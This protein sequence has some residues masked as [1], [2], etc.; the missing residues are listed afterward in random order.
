MSSLP[1]MPS[2]ADRPHG[3]RVRYMTGC[4]CEPCRASNARYESQRALARLRGEGAH[5]VPAKAARLHIRRLSRQGVGYKSVA[6]AADVS[7]R[8]VH[9]IRSGERRQ[10]RA[11][12]ERKILAVDADARADASIVPAKKTLKLIRELL[13]EGF[14][15]AELARRLGYKKPVLQI[16]DRVQARTA[17]RIERLHRRLTT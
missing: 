4:R 17:A 5:L 1:G 10:I 16:G 14:T 6:E 2:F 15:M 7:L 8:V 9:R 3:T 12:T 11:T 13:T